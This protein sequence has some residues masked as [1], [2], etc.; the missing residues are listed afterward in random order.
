MHCDINFKF[1]W[2]CVGKCVRLNPQNVRFSGC[3][4][5]LLMT[6]TRQTLTIGALIN[7]LVQQSLTEEFI[8]THTCKS[9]VLLG[10]D[11]IFIIC[12]S[13]SSVTKCCAYLDKDCVVDTAWLREICTIMILWPG[14]FHFTKLIFKQQA[15]LFLSLSLHPTISS[16]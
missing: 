10:L 16:T 4:T 14:Y 1:Y 2:Q 8:R 6:C 15:R 11:T 3:G 12:T 5:A 7:S 9:P 13:Y